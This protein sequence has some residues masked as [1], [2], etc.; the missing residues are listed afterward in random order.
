MENFSG[1]VWRKQFW[2][3]IFAS[4]IF[5][6]FLFYLD[7]ST[8]VRNEDVVQLSIKDYV[9]SIMGISPHPNSQLDREN[10]VEPMSQSPINTNRPERIR[11][12][13]VSDNHEDFKRVLV[14]NSD[15]GIGDIEMDLDNIVEEGS[16]PCLGRYVYVHKL[17]SQ[18]NSDILKDCRRLF[19]WTNMCH[20]LSNGGLGPQIEN[21]EVF[22]RKGWF[23]TDHFALDVIFHNRMKQ[24]KC[25]TTN[26]S[27]ASAIYVPF[28]A[29]FDI[30]RYLWG[31]NR[32]IRDST[33]HDV[34]KWLTSRPEWKALGGGDHFLLAGRVTWDFRR[35]TDKDSDW[36]NNLMVVPPAKNM[37]MLV[38]ESSPWHSND[39]AIPYP[40]YFHPSTDSE[41]FQWQKK[42]RRVKKR[43]LFSFAGAPRPNQPGSIRSQLINQCQA[44]KKCKLLE[45]DKGG[46]IC[47]S[48]SG[49]MKLFQNSVFC[50][51][52]PG[53]S[54][55]RRSAFDSILAGCIPVFFHPGS[56]YTQYIWHLPRNYTKYSVFIPENDIRNGKV[57]IEWTLNRIPKE[58]VKAMRKEV[59][60][61]IPKL[62]YADP[63]SRLETLEDAFDIAVKGVIQRTNG[64]RQKLHG[65]VSTTTCKEEDSW[66]CNLFGTREEREW[67]Q[68]FSIAKDVN[69]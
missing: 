12:I 20:S 31:F 58:D 52:P 26:S 45:C 64:L 47:H 28:Y 54:Y 32:S 63:R 48:P 13:S 49:I 17:P 61:L 10:W 46:D 25:L 5:S 14:N 37:S 1:G 60:N 11:N 59:V 62:I 33:S 35:V 24:Y 53:D 9:Y 39:F 7:W 19:P 42:M 65:R 50:L 43:Y 8:I 29:G 23:A 44:S 34:M 67:D 36:G 15:D 6:F 16:D 2:C 18:F 38:I 3:V 41:V 68:F 4:F 27:L 21:S 51:Q 22:P 57:N 56:A 66:K 30:G 55:T 69:S 40:T